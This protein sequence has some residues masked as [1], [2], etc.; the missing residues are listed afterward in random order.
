M[1]NC[2]RTITALLE[3]GDLSPLWPGR[4]DESGDLSPHSKSVLVICPSF[5]PIPRQKLTPTSNYTPLQSSIVNRQYSMAPHAGELYT[6]THFARGLI[7]YRPVVRMQV[8]EAG[9]VTGRLQSCIFGMAVRA[10]ERRIDLA[11]ADKAIRHPGKM[12]GCRK[13]G[14]SHPAVAGEA[15]IIGIQMTAHVSGKSEVTAAVDRASKGRGDIS[16]T[17][18]QF[19][20]EAKASSLRRR[21][22][23]AVRRFVA[24]CAILRRPR[25]VVASETGSL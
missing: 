4:Q 16:E 1:V 12:L 18:V 6:M 11:V 10:A 13:I 5:A 9:G 21:R 23:R 25:A 24:E 8:D 17:K 7:R 15:G 3:C 22:S 2:R 14:F 20:I 19:V